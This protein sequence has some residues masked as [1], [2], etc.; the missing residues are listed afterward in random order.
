MNDKINRA[1][2]KIINLPHATQGET[3]QRVY[4]LLVRLVRE[5]KGLKEINKIIEDRIDWTRKTKELNKPAIRLMLTDLKFE[6]KEK[7]L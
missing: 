6:I 5:E 3:E 1:V 4:N 2:M 7:L